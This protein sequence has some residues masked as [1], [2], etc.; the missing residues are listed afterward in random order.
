MAA[1]LDVWLFAVDPYKGLATPCKVVTGSVRKP[2]TSLC[3]AADGAWLFAGTAAGEVLTVNV[4]RRAV[5]V[6]R[7]ASQLMHLALMSSVMH[8]LMCIRVFYGS[9]NI[10]QH[11]AE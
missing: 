10:H 9:A 5:Q 11:D 6:C 7:G 4:A 1:E 2:L 3:F 8:S